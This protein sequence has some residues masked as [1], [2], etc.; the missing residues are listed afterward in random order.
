VSEEL[1]AQDTRVLFGERTLVVECRFYTVIH[2]TIVSERVRVACAGPKLRMVVG[3]LSRDPDGALVTKT[4][5]NTDE[6]YEEI[7]ARIHAMNPKPVRATVGV[8]D[9]REAAGLWGEWRAASGA[10]RR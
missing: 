1:R 9:R 3:G 4:F 2:Y 5:I 6:T 7:A 8:A 10:G